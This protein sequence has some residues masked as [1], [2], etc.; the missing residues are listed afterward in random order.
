MPP[1]HIKV[2]ARK[3][4]THPRFKPSLNSGGLTLDSIEALFYFLLPPEWIDL[5]MKYTN[6]F[7]DGRDEINKQLTKGELLRFFGYMISLSIHSGIALNKMWSKT[8]PPDSTASAHG[9][10]S[11]ECASR[12]LGA[13]HGSRR[14]ADAFVLILSASSVCHA[15]A[16]SRASF[17]CVVAGGCG[18]CHSVG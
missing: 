5:I 8:P 6:P 3:E 16:N 17:T 4:T 18:W 2:D 1:D 7:L 9:D 10:S 12:R 15:S 14:A 11:A 13:T